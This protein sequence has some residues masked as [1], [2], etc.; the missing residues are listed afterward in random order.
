MDALGL[1]AGSTIEESCA[2]S[3]CVHCLFSANSGTHAAVGR[4]GPPR[5]VEHRIDPK[6]MGKHTPRPEDGITRFISVGRL[7]HWKGFHFGLEAFAKAAIP[8]AEFV[9]V[10]SGPCLE[11]LR[12]Q[13]NALGIGDKV[14]FTG[15][16]PWRDAL[17]QFQDADVL[18]HPACTIPAASCCWRPWNWPKPVICLDLGGPGVYVNAEC[19]F[20]VKAGTVQ[21]KPSAISHRP[22]SFWRRTRP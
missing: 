10:G 16:L 4:E 20:A 15:E 7:L 19:G 5:D 14:R 2:I 1:R 22:C 9:V 8:K 6:A 11:P 13:A 21:F 3:E 17:K 18:V 12:E